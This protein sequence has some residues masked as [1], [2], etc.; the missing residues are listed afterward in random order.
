MSKRFQPTMN[1]L[2]MRTKKF[3]IHTRTISNVRIFCQL[4][5]KVLHE[6]VSCFCQ[7]LAKV[8][9]IFQPPNIPLRLRFLIF[10][11]KYA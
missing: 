2:D 6:I 7:R 1:V 11:I 3:F 9:Q 4:S 8:G 10:V 5:P